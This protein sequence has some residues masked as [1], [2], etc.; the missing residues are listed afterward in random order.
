MI[1]DLHLNGSDYDRNL[2]LFELKLR[3]EMVLKQ[4]R[5]EEMSKSYL[6]VLTIINVTDVVSIQ[7]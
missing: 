5:I 3:I 6:F 1:R 2:N 4:P 7:T